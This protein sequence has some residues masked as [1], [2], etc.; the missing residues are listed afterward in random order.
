MIVMD[1][2]AAMTGTMM[3]ILTLS[4]KSGKDKPRTILEAITNAHW[5]FAFNLGRTFGCG[6]DCTCKTPIICNFQMLIFVRSRG[7]FQ[8][9]SSF[10]SFRMGPL[11]TSNGSS[12]NGRR[13]KDM[14]RCA[15][16]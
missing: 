5:R 2:R 6:S 13:S 14:R 11:E 4:R 12:K 16:V 8:L 15:Y 10:E 3:D 1:C 9:K 7:H